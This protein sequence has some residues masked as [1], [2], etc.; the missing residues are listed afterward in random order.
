MPFW[1]MLMLMEVSLSLSGIIPVFSLTGRLD[2]TSSPLLEE[3]IKPLLD[4]QGQK[5]VFDCDGLTYVSSA[6]L[7]VFLTCQRQLLA[8]GG[9]VAFAS[10]SKPV[11]DLFH[12]A[13]LHDL[14]T[15]ERTPEAA[16]ARL[17]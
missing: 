6:G 11:Q 3:R 13:G 5:L 12:L 9:G 4:E 14:F 16:A 17:G 7:R 2:A 10:L 1:V 8:Q 15:I